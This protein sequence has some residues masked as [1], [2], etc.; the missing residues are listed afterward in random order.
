MKGRRHAAGIRPALTGMLLAAIGWLAACSGL[1]DGPA[2][3]DF[4]ETGRGVFILCEG[5]YNSGNASLSYYD[6]ETR[7]VQNGIFLR[8]NDRKLGDTGQ[9]IA[10]RNATAYIAVENSGIL[11][12]IDAGTFKVKGQL[13]APQTEHM[14]NPRYVHFLSDQKAYV[15]DLYS[16]YIT[17][18]N[19]ANCQYLGSISTG[20][21]T[22]YGYC[23]TEQ[24]VQCGGLVITNCWC[25]SDL[26]L[27]IDP[28]LDAVVDSIH[29]R[30]SMQPKS[31]VR[32]RHDRLWVITDGGYQADDDAFGDNIPHLYCIDPATRTILSDQALDTDEGNVQLATNQ[33]ADTLYVINNDIYRMAINESHLP[34]RPFI[35]APRDSKGRRH[36]LYG[37][38]VDPRSGDL[39][40]ADAVD[41]AQSGVIYRYSSSGHLLDTFRV[42]INPN[43]FA[44][45]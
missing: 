20:Q 30:T 31:M 37:L 23:S 2:R 41:Y 25:Y 3:E 6:P 39:Y 24:M 28:R 45:K 19:P 4:S 18:F 22:L 27:I 44:F 15:T 16:P 5:N 10:L 36:K 34:V 12:A 8:A 33:Q 13:T 17:I 42:G 29:L 7:Q 9:S 11:W 1:E 21:P 32:D 38:S 43:G 26:L 40:V 14:I 35:Q